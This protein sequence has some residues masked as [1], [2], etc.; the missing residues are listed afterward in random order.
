LRRAFS[1]LPCTLKPFKQF[2]PACN[3]A[4][5]QQWGAE[6]KWALVCL[7]HDV[8]LQRAHLTA[9]LFEL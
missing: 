6:H 8:A 1:I 4:A 7:L 5:Q 3:T 2:L 9:Q